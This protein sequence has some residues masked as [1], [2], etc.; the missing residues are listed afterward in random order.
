MFRKKKVEVEKFSAEDF[1][2]QELSLAF[3]SHRDTLINLCSLIIQHEGC[4][5]MLPEGADKNVEL[6]QIDTLQKRV[7]NVLAAYDVDY[8]KWQEI[9]SAKLIHY[10]GK[11]SWANSHEMLKIA[12]TNAYQRIMRG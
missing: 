9:D 10:N 4:S 3:K 5:H 12:W 6:E 11:P 2:L 1:L 8:H 7:R